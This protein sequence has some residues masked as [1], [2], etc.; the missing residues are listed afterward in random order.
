LC[1]QLMNVETSDVSC[2]YS[3]KTNKTSWNKKFMFILIN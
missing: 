3:I 1:G 2:L